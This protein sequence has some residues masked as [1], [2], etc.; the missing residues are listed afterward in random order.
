MDA[1]FAKTLAASVPTDIRRPHRAAKGDVPP[2]RANNVSSARE[3]DL[4]HVLP[5]FLYAEKREDLQ[6]KIGGTVAKARGRKIEAVYCSFSGGQK[7]RTTCVDGSR[8]L[9]P[10]GFVCKMRFAH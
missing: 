6:E 2:Q 8:M 5:R 4:S 9:N 7:L 1:D 10:A 3:L